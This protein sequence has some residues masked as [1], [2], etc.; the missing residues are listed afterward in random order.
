MMTQQ[1][2][3][4]DNKGEASTRMCTGSLPVTWVPDT[5][6]HDDDKVRRSLASGCCLP[7]FTENTFIGTTCII[8][9]LSPRFQAFSDTNGH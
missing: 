5:T 3:D 2:R 9:S 4:D 8:A 6:N 1:Q 7:N